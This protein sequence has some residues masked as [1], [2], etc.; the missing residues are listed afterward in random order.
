MEELE[1]EDPQKFRR[2]V[3]GVQVVPFSMRD[4]FYRIADDEMSKYT[5]KSKLTAEQIKQRVAEMKARREKEQL[6]KDLKKRMKDAKNQE[7]LKKVYERVRKE[8]LN[9][10]VPITV[11]AGGAAAG[12]TKSP[13]FTDTLGKTKKK[14]S[15]VE[16]STN[17]VLAQA[18][19]YLVRKNVKEGNPIDDGKN[20]KVTL[21]LLQHMHYSDIAQNLP[22]DFQPNDVLA[23]RT[24]F[25][26]SSSDSSILMSYKSKRKKKKT[27]VTDATKPSNYSEKIF[28]LKM[29]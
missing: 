25:E 9:V 15:K 13:P 27:A 3:K 20:Q 16:P 28:S 2:K 26:D 11:E 12:N 4:K 22:D 29:Q 23:E 6:L 24:E 17:D 19:S 10:N 21:D 1:A 5:F 14:K 8:R 7:H 18:E